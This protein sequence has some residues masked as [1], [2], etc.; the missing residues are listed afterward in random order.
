MELSEQDLTAARNK[1]NYNM[2]KD[3]KL[4]EGYNESA[5]PNGKLDKRKAKFCLLAWI[6]KQKKMVCSSMLGVKECYVR[7]NTFCFCNSRNSFQIQRGSFIFRKE[8]EQHSLDKIFFLSRLC[9]S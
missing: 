4:R 3:E 5:L 9:C 1:F 7:F 8:L 6:F 2:R